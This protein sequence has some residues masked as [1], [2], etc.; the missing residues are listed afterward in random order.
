MWSFH[1][2]EKVNGVQRNP[3]D[4]EEEH[5]DGEVLCG[6]DFSLPGSSKNSQHAALSASTG[7]VHCHHLL[8]LYIR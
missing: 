3:A 5:D 2:L 1:Y 4:H 8:Q 7:A 6:F